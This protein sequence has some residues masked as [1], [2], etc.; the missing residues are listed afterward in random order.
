MNDKVR[1]GLILGLVALLAGFAGAIVALGAISL[2]GG[3]PARLVTPL[4][5]TPTPTQTPSPP[6]LRE[7]FDKYPGLKAAAF[8]WQCQRL[9]RREDHTSWLAFRDHIRRVWFL[10]SGTLVDLP[11]E[12]PAGWSYD[13]GLTY[14][15]VGGRYICVPTDP[16]LRRELGY[17]GG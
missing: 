11:I 8:A 16:D 10:G 17:I 12:T 1:S 6:T 3:D 2:M 4:I 9:N 14:Y 7:L 13:V 15:L 5:R